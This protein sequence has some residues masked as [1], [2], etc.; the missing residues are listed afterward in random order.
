MPHGPDFDWLHNP[1]A[2]DDPKFNPQ[3]TTILSRMHFWEHLGRA[4]WKTLDEQ[5]AKKW[6]WML[7]D[8][9]VECPMERYEAPSKTDHWKTINVGLRMAGSW[10]NSYYRFL[11]SP[12]FTPQA[13][14]TY[15]R[16]IQ[17]SAKRLLYGLSLD[18]RGGN[19]VAMESNGL[20]SLAT[21]FPEFKDSEKWKKLALDRL[22]QE[23]DIQIYPDG[24]QI[25]L[26]P[27]Y[28]RTTIDQFIAP[29]QLAK[30]NQADFPEDYVEN[31][32]LMYQA[33]ILAQAPSGNIVPT[34][35]SK[36]VHARSIAREGLR[37]FPQDP[38]IRWAASGGTNGPA[39]PVSNAQPYAGY[40]HFRSGW[41]SEDVHVM[42]DVG[43]PGAGHW[44]E[45]K[46]HFTLSAF[47]KL[48]LTDHGYYDYDQS[49]WRYFSLG[50][51]AHNTI[52][53]D[54]K[55]QHR[56]EYNFRPE[57]VQAEFDAAFLPFFDFAQATYEEGYETASYDKT[58][59]YH[60]FTWKGDR[61][62]EPTHT[63]YLLYFKPGV[64]IVLD[65]LTGGDK[66]HLVESFFHTS[67][68]DSKELSPRH[69]R[70]SFGEKTYLD[71]VSLSSDSVELEAVS[72]Q[73]E[74]EL[75]GWNIQAKKPH[76]T[77]IQKTKATPPAWMV[78]ALLPWQDESPQIKGKTM[79]NGDVING[80]LTVEA[81]KFEFTLNS[82][83]DQSPRILTLDASLQ[84][85][86]RL[87]TRESTGEGQVVQAVDAK[88][89]TTASCQFTSESALDVTLWSSEESTKL[90]VVADSGE[91]SVRFSRPPLG[92]KK[93]K[94][95]NWYELTENGLV[96]TTAPRKETQVNQVV[97]TGSTYEDYRH[98]VGAARG[99]LPQPIL[100]EA[101]SLDR[102]S[103][104]KTGKKIGVEKQVV[105]A[106]NSPGQK[107]K[108]KL[109][110]AEPVDVAIQ[111]RYA[112]GEFPVR[113]IRLN[114]ESPFTE[115]QNIP[116][117]TTKGEPPSGGWGN[118]A[119]DFQTV[120]LGQHQYP[121]GYRF[122][123]QPGENVIEIINQDGS[124]MN[125]DWI[126]FLPVQAG[127]ETP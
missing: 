105:T 10:P 96:P 77:L 127:S 61:Q 65:Q 95:E 97:A 63:R 78:M 82:A 47:G 17:D 125:L 116:F 122:R 52:S 79:G 34:N 71:A 124:G 49:L 80:E 50:T 6:V 46:L 101:E 2:P 35:D 100:F 85:E 38:L 20:Y 91:V 29:M 123:L 9:A 18:N 16:L 36:Q 126:E 68:L 60:P 5:Y 103:G 66:E 22:R 88:K 89:L 59:A 98:Q 19:W 119:D 113:V 111:F 57:K 69:Y 1:L 54:G 51:R 99:M 64:L 92:Q 43:P 90:Q 121:E 15:A 3:Y 56:G 21:L 114:G 25:E 81:A 72:G 37:L 7:E 11:H 84:S 107:L 83:F 14:L 40:L 75:M 110:V 112:S 42:F 55:W 13:N 32:R 94:A 58:K 115:A 108:A 117:D 86:A 26:T 73:K 33:L 45:D 118:F 102:S 12:S 28:H 23:M 106:W 109:M 74:P 104:L 41:G 39:P 120:V 93:L 76:P 30:L 70:I 8:F 62:T 48:M 44:H 24:W 53:V 67:G 87:L 4:Y 27:M 31:L